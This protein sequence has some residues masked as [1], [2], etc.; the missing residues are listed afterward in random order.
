MPRTTQSKRWVFTL[1]NYTD[2]DEQFL[3]D[4]LNNDYEDIPITEVGGGVKY[5][6]FGREVGESG[7]PHLQG[8]VIFNGNVRLAGLHA[9]L[10]RAHFEIARGTSVQARNYITQNPD[11]P[12]ADFDEFGEFP[13]EQGKRTDLDRAIEWADEFEKQNNRP[14]SSPEIA[15]HF[16]KVYISHGRFTR[17]CEH[18]AKPVQLQFGEPNEFQQELSD[19]LD[20][21]PDD[22]KVKFIVDA[23]GGKGK[24]WF[25]RW[26]LTAKP[27]SVQILGVGKRDDLAHM[28]ET[29]KSIFFF[30][31]PRGG[32]EFLQYTILEQLKDRLVMSPKYHSKMKVF[33]HPN[34]VV[35][36]CN[37][38]PDFTKMS[39]DRY[40]V[41]YL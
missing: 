21:T 16:P 24:T 18:R 10:P 2:D 12:N 27:A 1:N 25:Q 20:G 4:W 5:G 26:Y 11:K 28:I 3:G 17:M 32:M 39:E 22:R 19:Y 41:Q 34:H 8:F 35:V 31:I 33:R 15:K 7:T 30:N 9:R 38:D 6:V 40:D 14:P 13:T 23:E 37:E 29:E 36:F